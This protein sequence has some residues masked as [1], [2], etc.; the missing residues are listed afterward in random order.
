VKSRNVVSGFTLIEVMIAVAIVATLAA[1][2]IPRYHASVFR[3]QR[4]EAVLDLETINIAQMSHYGVY[5]RFTADFEHL[6]HGSAGALEAPSV[7]RGRRYTY[8]L[9]QPWGARSWVCTASA[10]LD[11]DPWPDLLVAY[12]RL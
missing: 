8:T 4:V 6:D 11:G 7:H 9:S 5:D 2:A 12:E 10:D 3:A 1:L